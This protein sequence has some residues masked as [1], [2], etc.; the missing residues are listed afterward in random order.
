MPEKKEPKKKRIV[1]I[2]ARRA[3]AFERDRDRLNTEAVDAAHAERQQKKQ[4]KKRKAGGQTDDDDTND[5][6]LLGAF[7]RA[8]DFEID[9]SGR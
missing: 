2:S 6:A 4:N 9:G 1:A 5:D 7:V 3:A 8:H